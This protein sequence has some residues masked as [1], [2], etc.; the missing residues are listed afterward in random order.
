MRPDV[1]FQAKRTV[2]GVLLGTSVHRFL[3]TAAKGYVRCC[4]GHKS[5]HRRHRRGGFGGKQALIT[6]Y[7]VGPVRR[8]LFSGVGTVGFK[9]KS[10]G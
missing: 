4:A 9:Q 8:G 2:K 1:R 10:F 6:G 5:R 7:R 3:R